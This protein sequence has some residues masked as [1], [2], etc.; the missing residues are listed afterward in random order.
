MAGRARL[1]G[2]EINTVRPATPSYRWI[3]FD[4]DGTLYDFNAAE[5]TALNQTFGAFGLEV[6]PE[7]HAA[8]RSISLDLWA[9]FERGELS[10]ATLRVRR[11]EILL[12]DFGFDPE[13]QQVSDRYIRDLG[14][15]NPLL[16]DAKAVVETLALRF[17]LLLATNGIAEIQRRRFGGSEIRPFF[18]DVVISDEI[19]VAKPDPAY[20]DVVFDRMG[21]PERSEVLMVGDGLSSDIAGG[22]GYGIDT[23]WINA[24]ADHNESE[25]RPTYIIDRLTDLFPIVLESSIGEAR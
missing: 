15:Q 2:E 17:K 16:P 10:S 1:E 21:H 19:G 20:F 12:G 23:C 25:P 18:R 6:T 3:V 4:A 8:Y 22:V 24:A 7:I 11:F 5:T 14:G 13:P 9:A